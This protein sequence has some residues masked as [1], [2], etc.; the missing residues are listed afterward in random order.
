MAERKAE[1]ICV[2][3]GKAAL[4]GKGARYCSRGCANRD[5][6]NKGSQRGIIGGEQRI[7]ANCGTMLMAHRINTRYCGET[8]RTKADNQ[9]SAQH[10]QNRPKRRKVCAW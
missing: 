5:N 2:Y 9:R 8:C 6:P 7:C 10:R 1:I 3:C 4:M